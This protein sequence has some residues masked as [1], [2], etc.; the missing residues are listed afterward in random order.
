MKEDTC[1]ITC[2]IIQNCPDG[3]PDSI[4]SF[5]GSIKSIQVLTI[6]IK[7]LKWLLPDS[8]KEMFS[9]GVGNLGTI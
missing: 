9:I 4:P 5:A 1:N 6:S 8:F 7:D 3:C 2:N